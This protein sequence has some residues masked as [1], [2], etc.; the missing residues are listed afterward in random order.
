MANCAVLAGHVEVGNDAIIG[1]FNAD[2]PVLPRRR[3]RVPRRLHGLPAGRAAVLPD[4]RARTPKTYGLNTIGL[5]R[6]GFSDERIEALQK[7]YRFLVKSKLNTSQALERI[8]R[9]AA[10]RAR[11]RGARPVHPVERAG[12]HQVRPR[13]RRAGAGPVRLAVVG[14]G[15]LGRHHARVA[16]DLPAIALVGIHDHHEAGPR[17]WRGSTA[18]GVLS[19]PDEVAEAARRSSSR[20]RRAPTASSAGFFLERG[21]DVLVEKPIAPARGRGRRRWWRWPARGR[22]CSRWAT[23]SATTRRSRPCSRRVATPR[24]IEGHRLGD[25]HPAQPRRGRGPRPDDPRP[26]DRRG[27]R[28]P[29]GASRFAPSACRC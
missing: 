12:L 25:L 26:A 8:A 10:R 14:V 3:L 24:F 15:H 21:L 13:R 16:A 4:R 19:G 18:C 27:P 28:A 1:A 17:R 23:S 2:P 6:N 29:A 20:R 9:G 22:G 5:K 11:R 7:A